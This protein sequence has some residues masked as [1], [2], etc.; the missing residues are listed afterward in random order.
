MSSP[1]P[2]LVLEP[3]YAMVRWLRDDAPPMGSVLLVDTVMRAPSMSD[4][5]AMMDV[6]PWCPV[7][8]LTDR[9]IGGRGTRRVPRTCQVVGLDGQGDGTN[10]ILRSV[11]DRPRPTPSTLVEWI[12]RRT[13]IHA[14][15]RT[16]SD[17]F[18]RPLLRR[19][20][21]GYLPFQ[22]RDHLAMLGTWNALDWQ[23]AAQFAEYAADRTSLNRL[24][25]D[26]APCAVETRER[27][28]D[29]LGVS[30]REFHVAHGW[31]W[32]LELSLRRSGCFEQGAKDFRRMVQRRS[33]MPVRSTGL[34]AYAMRESSGQRQIA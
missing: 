28:Q 20:E 23:H 6:A 31:E 25:S 8:I 34:P 14:I 21:A 27:M 7:C 26:S 1:L 5:R 10:A 11:D 13:K 3:P 32:V 9:R 29:L 19:V 30:D 33:A 22:A 16:L 15:G 18:S 17:L 4:L 2:L 24:L 12:V